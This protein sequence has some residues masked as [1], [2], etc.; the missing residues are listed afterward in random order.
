[1]RLSSP[2]TI[3]GLV[4]ALPVRAQA[5]SHAGPTNPPSAS[6]A[7]AAKTT[8]PSAAPAS[9]PANSLIDINTA[10]GDQLDA[11]PQAGSAR[12]DT[13]QSRIVA[14]PQIEVRPSGAV[15]HLRQ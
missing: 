10:S 15:A 3:P 8:T 1:M 9:A 13:I 7:P 12:A 4:L 11:L 2:V 5:A 6:A 14:R